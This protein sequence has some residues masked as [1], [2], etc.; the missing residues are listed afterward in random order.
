MR[1][2]IPSFSNLNDVGGWRDS[3][4]ILVPTDDE[5]HRVFFTQNVQIDEK[6]MD[7]F[8]ATHAKFDARVAEHRPIA[9]I[10]HDV[11]AGR[12]HISE[13]L[14]HPHLLLLEDAITQG[15]QGQKVDR[16]MELLGRTDVG[17]VAMRKVFDREMR[18]VANGE[19]TK[20]WTPMEVDPV[21]GF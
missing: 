9:D 18:A 5:N 15:G 13:H 8:H 3:Y 6:D 10:A 16:N 21:L 2:L 4:I 12:T 14:D 19:P 7:A 20:G 1:I 17:I 11:L